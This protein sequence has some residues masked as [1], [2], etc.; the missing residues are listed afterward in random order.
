MT[1]LTVQSRPGTF[2]RF[3]VDLFQAA[4]D[5]ATF[6]GRTNHWYE[7]FNYIGEWHSHPSFTVQPSGKDLATMRELVRDAA[8]LG[9]FAILMIVR[10]ERGEIESKAMLFEPDGSQG[11]VALEIPHGL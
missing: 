10:L 9:S 1:E 5:A 8:F 3:F 7:R 11:T 6:F 2:A 4:R